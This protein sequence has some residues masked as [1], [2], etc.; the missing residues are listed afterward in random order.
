MMS[1]ICE[2]HDQSDLSTALALAPREHLAIVGGGGKTTLMFTLSAVIRK[3]GKRVLTTTTT[4]L[5]HG[6]ALSLPPVLFVQSDVSWKKD[7]RENLRTRGHAFLAENVLASGKVQGID[8]FLA[9]DLFREEI[10]DYLI[11]EADGAAGHPVKAHADHEPVIPGSAT[12]VVALL[13]LE[14]LGRP[15]SPETVFREDLFHE[16]TGC[17]PGEALSPSVLFKLISSPKGIFKGAPA[18][19]QKIIFLN[20]A[21]LLVQDDRARELVDL[22]LSDQTR[23]IH[24]II[25]GTLTKDQYSTV[26]RRD[27]GHFPEDC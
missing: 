5:W 14:A 7:L 18:S 15:L 3:A 19:A 16:L 10:M 4:K 1:A 6:E 20:K 2:N 11:V 22:L 13:G 24:R 27:G 23:K 8:P 25:I 17:N 26:R 12:K 9:D 21:D